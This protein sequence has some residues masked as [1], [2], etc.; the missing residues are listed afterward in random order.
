MQS[1]YTV[2]KCKRCRGEMV[3]LTEEVKKATSKGKYLACTY[4]GCKEPKKI[5]ETDNMKEC[6][7]NS[8]KKR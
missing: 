6:F 7:D 2:Y 1:I 8:E 4:C 3:L 5:K